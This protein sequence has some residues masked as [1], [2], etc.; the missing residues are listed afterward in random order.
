MF[1]H[2]LIKMPLLVVIENVHGLQFGCQLDNHV[3][4]QFIHLLG[5]HRESILAVVVFPSQNNNNV[6]PLFGVL[7]SYG[8]VDNF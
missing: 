7:Q 3:E 2:F 4:Y 8:N 6:Q 1:L 5:Y